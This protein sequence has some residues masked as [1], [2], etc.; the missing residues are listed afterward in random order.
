[1]TNL[2]EDEEKD[3]DVDKKKDEDEDE[4]VQHS[5]HYK[6]SN[7]RPQKAEKPGRICRNFQCNDMILYG[8]PHDMLAL[9]HLLFHSIQFC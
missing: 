3:E 2:D 6:C 8:V 4:D 9:I 5:I 1:M 7:S